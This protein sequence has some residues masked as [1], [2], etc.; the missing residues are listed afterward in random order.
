MKNSL[1][2]AQPRPTAGPHPHHSR[3]L[4]QNSIAIAYGVTRFELSNTSALK[5]AAKGVLTGFLIS[6]RSFSSVDDVKVIVFEHWRCR[7]EFFARSLA[8]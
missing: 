7:T 5:I 8:L 6:T 4:P 3:A 1:F 2:V